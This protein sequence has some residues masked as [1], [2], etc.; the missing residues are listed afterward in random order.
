MGMKQREIKLTTRWQLRHLTEKGKWK[1][2]DKYMD[3][4]SA[5]HNRDRNIDRIRDTG[6]CAMANFVPLILWARHMLVMYAFWIWLFTFHAWVNYA[7]RDESRTQYFDVCNYINLQIVHKLPWGLNSPKF[8]TFF[9]A[10]CSFPF[11]HKKLYLLHKHPRRTCNTRT[12]LFWYWV[13]CLQL[14]SFIYIFNAV[15]LFLLTAIKQ[16]ETYSCALVST[17]GKYEFCS[18]WV[19]L[20]SHCT[21]IYKLPT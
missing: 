16:I 4:L 21:I 8:A 6:S 11:K 14:H 20:L 2:R 15:S 18:C 12:L 19:V 13:N 5:W 1:T 9:T 3:G 7:L 10:Q 17:C